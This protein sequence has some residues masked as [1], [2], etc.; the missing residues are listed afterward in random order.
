MYV[1]NTHFILQSVLKMIIPARWILINLI[2]S[3][4][5]NFR[6]CNSHGWLDNVKV[7]HSVLIWNLNITDTPHP[8]ELIFVIYQ[9]TSYELLSL[10]VLVIARVRSYDLLLF[11]EMRVSFCIPVPL[12]CLLHELQVTF[13]IQVTSCKW[14]GELRINF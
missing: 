9:W 6:G 4:E 12:Y 14:L 5:N 8:S 10:R 1:S 2:N 3:R 13:Y 7:K 11:H